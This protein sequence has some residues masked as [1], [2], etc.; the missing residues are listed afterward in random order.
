MTR[1]E[2]RDLSTRSR[3]GKP[4]M[5]REARPDYA[6]FVDWRLFRTASAYQPARAKHMAGDAVFAKKCGDKLEHRAPQHTPA[7]RQPGCRC[8][9]SGMRQML[10][11]F[12]EGVRHFGGLD[13][14][15][16]LFA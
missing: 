6:A 16:Q 1:Q 3:A 12:D 14:D 8:S 5:L 11:D 15:A 7:L 13:G 9:G 4:W 10:S 2:V